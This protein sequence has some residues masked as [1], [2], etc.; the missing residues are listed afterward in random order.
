MSLRPPRSRVGGAAV[1]RAQALAEASSAT[2]TEVLVRADDGAFLRGWFFRPAQGNGDAVI[3]LHGV[4]DSR[5]GMLGFARLFLPKGYAVLLPDARHHGES[6]G[7]I[8]TFGVREA[9]DI[10]LWV[11][12]IEDEMQPRC[13][14]ALAESM[15]AGQLLQSLAEEDRF[16]AVVAESPYATF[17]EVAHDRVGRAFGAGPWL[18]RTILRIS[19]ESAM[20]YARL[21]YGMDLARANPADAVRVTQTP[22]LLIHG[23]ADRNIPARHAE[24][25]R[26]ANAGLGLWLV[27]GAG[28]SA[29]LGT[30]PVEFEERV[31]SWFTKHAAQRST[32]RR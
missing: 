9:R 23:T 32:G 1:K 15:G 5:V 18:G 21:R 6:E 16:C 29:A 3:L 2:L 11:S 14:F 4:A 26:A 25:L 31:M 30:A 12:S 17:R 24:M 8:A 22:I 28:H 13:V 10:S 7:D 19:L 27:P 20:L